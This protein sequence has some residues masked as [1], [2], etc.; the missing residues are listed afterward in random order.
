MALRDIQTK[1]GTLAQECEQIAAKAEL[2]EADTQRLEQIAAE[3]V[4]LERQMTALKAAG[5][6][7]SWAK[8]S[9]GM[10]ALA[11]PG[12]PAQILGARP[13]GE[14]TITEERDARGRKSILVSEDG[15]ILMDA[16]KYKAISSADYGR[17][18]RQYLRLGDTGLKAG[19]FKVLQEGVD[20]SGGFTVP[21]DMLN[22]LIAK[23]PAPTNVAGRVTIL[24]T[25]RDSITIPKVV[26]TTD[27]QY[28][29]GMRVTWTGEIPAAATTHRVTEP[30]FGQVRI[31]IFTA[32][33][34]LPLTVDMVEDSAVDIV[35][36]CTG[37]FN[38]TVDLLFDNMIINGSGATQPDGILIN[39]Q[40]VTNDVHTGAAAALTWDGIHDLV[41]ALPEQYDRNA[42]VLMNKT[43]C[44]LALSKLQDGNG[45]PYWTS[46]SNDYGLAGERV[47]RPLMGYP[48][49]FNSFM[50]NVTA[51]LYPIVFGDLTGYYLVR[52]IGF[53]IQVLREL[54][55]ETNQILLLGRVRFGGQLVEDWRVRGHLVGA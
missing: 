18:F 37:K 23:E 48:V 34:S 4:Q 45:R 36:W 12:A 10:L 5:E 40:F 20:T 28:T 47:N 8:Q 33:M 24:N 43:N 50:P 32:M 30:S 25:S 51:A 54:Y 17:E 15:E 42:V 22:R 27:N 46:G 44:A 9:G 13:A 55:A 7:G 6:F 39:A 1:I 14:T 3:R 35:G 38:E 26:Y 31:P 19:T 41:Y 2:A 52:R 16:A 29:S 21:E 53:S 11:A 49:M